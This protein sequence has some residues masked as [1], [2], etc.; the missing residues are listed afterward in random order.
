MSPMVCLL[1]QFGWFT[2]ILYQLLMFILWH[3]QMV[4][5]GIPFGDILS[6]TLWYILWY[7]QWYH[8]IHYKGIVTHSVT[9]DYPKVSI[10]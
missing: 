9:D 8:R 6:A 4:L 1:D 7:I 10:W 3:I 5:H 2:F